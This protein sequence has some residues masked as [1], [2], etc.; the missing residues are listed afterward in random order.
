[1]N[2]IIKEEAARKLQNKHQQQQEEISSKSYKLFSEK[3]RP[4]EVAIELN[5]KEPEVTKLFIEY[6]KLR[7][8]HKFYLAYKE[9]GEEDIGYFVKLCKLAKKV[10]LSIEK[11]VNAVD[12]ASNK[13]PYMESLYRQ[14]KDEVDNMQRTRQHLSNDIHAL[15]YKISIL[16]KTAFSCEEDC[17]RKE[18]ELQELTIRKDRI[19][20]LIANI[21]NNDNG[22]HSKLKHMIK[23]NVKA[24]LAE[25]SK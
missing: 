10:G 1:M 15:E 6:C 8:L 24:V 4:I 3:K 18:Q 9:L 13:L 19:E 21:L 11:I 12:I 2:I 25:I 14:P 17:R 16:D 23:Q 5:L 20:K 7:R 22:V